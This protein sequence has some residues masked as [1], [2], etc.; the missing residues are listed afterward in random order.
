MNPSTGRSDR[1]EHKN[2]IYLKYDIFH[3][4]LFLR[5][6]EADLIVFAHL[7]DRQSHTEKLL[8]MRIQWWSV[9]INAEWG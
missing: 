8:F 5:Q 9:F 4:V 2:K 7:D 6:L 3:Q 1:T